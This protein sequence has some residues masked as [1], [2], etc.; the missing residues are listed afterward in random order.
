[1]AAKKVS[2]EDKKVLVIGAGGGAR[3]IVYAL[4]ESKAKNIY[5]ANRTLKNAEELAEIFKIK[6]VD[7]NKIGEVLSSV[8]L[9]VNTSAC[10]MK[11][12][13][14]LPFKVDKIKSSLIIYDLIYNK[15][16]PFTKLAGNK[17][18]KIF[19]G[20]GM[21]IRQGACGFKIWTGKYPD[22]KIAERLLKKFVE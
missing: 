12:I 11:K 19:T 18:L 21:L 16:T 17:R 15:L 8:D 20:V 2:L 1:L 3:A 4:K 22:I 9:L 5:I 7:I 10:G 13:D 14:I 6:A